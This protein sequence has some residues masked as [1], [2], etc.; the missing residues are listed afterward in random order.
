MKLNN[1]LQISSEGGHGPI[2]Y[3]LK[4]K[5][6]CELIE[7]QFT[8]PK[9]FIGV[10]RFEIKPRAKGITLI[11]HTIEMRTKGIDSLKWAFAIRWLHDALIEDCFDKLERN[12]GISQS[13]SKHSRWVVFLRFLTNRIVRIR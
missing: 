11:I 4:R 8:K 9:G 10:R 1:G 5:Q 7:F 2:K 12:L 13:I 6:N 3:F